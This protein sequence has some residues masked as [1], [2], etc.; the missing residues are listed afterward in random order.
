MIGITLITIPY[1]WDKKLPS[2]QATISQYRPDLLRHNPFSQPIPTT[3]PH[4]KK[5]YLNKYKNE[6]QSNLMLATD[7]Q[8][9]EDP[10]GWFMTEKFDGIR[11]FWTGKKMFSRAGKE[12][13]VPD[14]FLLCL[15]PV[16]LDGEL[17]YFLLIFL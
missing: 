13:K 3:K 9:G 2:L 1:W 10:T 14:F 7:W 16:A 11:V 5:E 15:P 8:P 17:W 12:I 6:I 4:N